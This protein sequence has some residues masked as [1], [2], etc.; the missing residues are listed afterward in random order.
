MIKFAI[1]GNIASGKTQVENILKDIG[2]KVFDADKIAHNILYST[3]KVKEEFK[4]YDILEHGE[5]SRKKLGNIVFNDSALRNRLEAIIHPLVKQEIKRLFKEYQN[6]KYVFISI[7]LLFESKMEDLF[8][9]I[10]LIYCDDDLR[11]KRLIKRNNL[12]EEEA[13]TRMNSQI[14]QQEK[15]NRSDY[16]LKNES[17]IDDLKQQLIDII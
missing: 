4:E 14:C 9:K 5:I 15:T 6:E 2:Y 3:D 11:L 12:T 7:P 16:I 1:T 17:T 13:L 8:D 10:I